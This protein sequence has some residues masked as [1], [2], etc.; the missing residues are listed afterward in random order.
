M[1]GRI[2][3]RGRFWWIAYFLNGKEIREVARDKKTG[4]KIEVAADPEKKQAAKFLELRKAKITTAKHGGPAFLGPQQEKVTVNEILDDVIADYKRGGKKGIPRELSPQMQSIVKQLRE[5]F[6]A[7]RA[8]NVGTETIQAFKDQ[9]K[10]QKKANATINRPLQLLAQAYNYAI[11][12]DPPKLSRALNIKKLMLDESGNRRTGKFSSAEAEAIASSLPSHMSDVAR[13]AYETGARAGEILALEWSHLDGE[14]INVPG[15]LCKNREPR[16]IAVNEQL[17]P[18]LKRRQQARAPKCSLI[19]HHDGHAIVDY[20]K[21]WQTACVTNGLGKYYC[22]DCR[23]A[24]GKYISV[25]DGDYKCPRC[26]RQWGDDKKYIGKIF[27][28][29]R[30]TAAYEMWKA[31]SSTDDCMK[32]T[33]HK[34]ASMFKRYADIFSKEE[35]RQ[36]QLEVQAR[37]KEW[38]LSQAA[39]IIPM[40]RRVV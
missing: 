29:F 14:V 24:S 18:I 13:F 39:N 4:E 10:T 3:P 8:V 11:S 17:E 28:D 22:R 23:D 16:S 7:M 21:C 36:R 2:F 40:P 30:R 38:R 25:L 15:E 32:V 27:H 20:R 19:F 5:F 6:G 1:T 12:T 33:G 37:R 9:L 35:D 31:G 26:Q 34:T